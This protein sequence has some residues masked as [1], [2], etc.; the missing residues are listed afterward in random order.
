MDASELAERAREERR[1][2]LEEAAQ[3][4]DALQCDEPAICSDPVHQTARAIAARIR[5]LIDR[6]PSRG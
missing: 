1:R 3:V 4:A 5:A 6:G 2:V